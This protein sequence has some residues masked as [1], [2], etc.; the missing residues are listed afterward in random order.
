MVQGSLIE[1]P[2]P[3]AYVAAPVAAPTPVAAPVVVVAAPA[4]VDVEA[5]AVTKVE[6]VIP[7]APKPAPDLNS[8]VQGA[9]LQWVQTVEPAEAFVPKAAAPRVPRVR[10]PKQVFDDVPLAQIETDGKKD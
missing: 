5:P 2:A 9:G 4:P 6:A 3:V 8:V 1:A 7:A 10:K